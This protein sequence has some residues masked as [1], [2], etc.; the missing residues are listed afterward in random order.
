MNCLLISANIKDDDNISPEVMESIIETYIE[1]PDSVEAYYKEVL[2]FQREQIEIEHEHFIN[3]SDYSPPAYNNKYTIDDELSDLVI[4]NELFI[5]IDNIKT[6]YSDVDSIIKA[7][8]KSIEDFKGANVSP[9][10]YAYKYQLKLIDVYSHLYHKNVLGL[11][12]IRGWGDFF[13][14]KTIDIFIALSIISLASFLFIS[15]YKAGIVNI[16]RCTKHGRLRIYFCKLVCFVSSCFVIIIAF[17]LVTWGVFGV[18]YGY[19]SVFNSIQIIDTFRFCP[20]DIN[21]LEFL[22]LFILFKVL[23]FLFFGIVVLCIS[24]LTYNMVITYISGIGIYAIN[25]VLYV[26]RYDNSKNI[27]KYV[28]LIS[29]SS[30]EPIFSKYLSINIFHYVIDIPVFMGY[31]LV[32]LITILILFIGYFYCCKYTIHSHNLLLN[33]HLIVKPAILSEIKLIS[34]KMVYSLSLFI[35]ESYKILI[36]SRGWLLIL[37]LFV[38]KIH[39]LNGMYNVAQT[40]PDKIYCE[41]MTEL[42]GEST[43]DKLGYI[44]SERKNI[45]NTLLIEPEIRD[46]YFNGHLSFTEY[47]EF[48]KQYNYALGRDGIFTRIEDHASYIEHIN[49]MGFSAWFVYDTGWEQLFHSDFDWT[50]YILCIILFTGMFSVEYDSTSSSGKFSSILR[51]TK[52][53]RQRTFATKIITAIVTST[54]LSGVWVLTDLIYYFDTYKMPLIDAPLKSIQSMQNFPVD[55]TIFQFLLMYI[56]VRIFSVIILTLFIINLSCIFRKPLSILSIVSIVTLFPLALNKMGITLLDNIDF[57]SYLRATPILLRG[58]E[59]II[60]TGIIVLIS[61]ILSVFSKKRWCI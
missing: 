31:F 13:S 26:F 55:V 23:S 3:G 48:L 36:S 10:S 9:E 15:E 1:D 42:C 57:V 41:Y 52:K 32:I 47:S 33:K 51:T 7:A 35:Y 30:V 27:L 17:L 34:K 25:Y 46:K 53:G 19:S 54:L 11:E 56:A 37:I 43:E 38:L 50:L 14:W 39:S 5:N 8:Q 58:R 18:K 20:Y 6:Y 21:I 59:F 49:S 2:D 40:Y 22:L 28:N 45:D 12:Y 44:Q 61:C 60:Y 29:T 4:L 24:V 16:I